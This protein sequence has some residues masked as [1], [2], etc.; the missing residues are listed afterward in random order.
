MLNALFRDRQTPPTEQRENISLS[1]YAHMWTDTYG[2]LFSSVDGDTS[3]RHDAV[4]SC[5]TRIAQ[6]VSMYPVDV[7]RYVGGER[8]PVEP[9]PQIVAAPSV[10]V[11]ALDWRYQVVDSWLGW[12]NA[13]GLVTQVTANGLYPTRIELLNPVQVTGSKLPGDRLRF[14]VDNVEHFRWPEGDLWHVPAYTSPGSV[15][16]MSPIQYHSSTITGG[17]NAGKFGDDFFV[18]GGLPSSILTVD[19][20]PPNAVE[21]GKLKQRLLD[22]TRGNRE[23]LVLPKGTTYEQISVNP[24]DSQFIESQRYSVEQICRIFGED[25]ADHGASA[26]GSSVT[27]ANRLDAETARIR[28][29]QFWIVKLQGALTELI[30]RPQSVRLNT[31]ASL[32]MTPIERHQ[33]HAVRLASKTQTI[34]E[35]RTIGDEKPFDGPEFDQPGIPGTPVVPSNPAADTQGGNA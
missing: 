33:L 11:S 19:P 24:S 31:D 13:W 21:A 25:P 17:L 35:V 30:A 20:P 2:G 29:R 27:Y 18:A 28:R 16:G 4:W 23:P 26:G 8:Q 9:V 5:R 10:N 34:N 12:G 6:D 14:F 7:V 32:M 1:A 22:L 3:M 15:T